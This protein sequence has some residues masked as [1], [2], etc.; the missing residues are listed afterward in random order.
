VAEKAPEALVAQARA[1]RVTAAAAKDYFFEPTPGRAEAVA[2]KRL[3]AR[4]RRTDADRA[5]EALRGRKSQWLVISAAAAELSDEAAWAVEENERFGASLGKAGRDLAG[6]LERAAERLC[7]AL[8]RLDEA[9]D[10]LAEAK[11]EALKIED[12]R[13][14]ARKAALDRPQ[15]AAEL[16]ARA[17]LDRFS[18]AAEAVHRAAD[19]A[20][21]RLA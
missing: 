8:E 16:S 11:N 19:A 9:Q 14:K 18:R 13:R 6:G 20:A 4:L 12:I 21:E 1:A 7:A 17:V 15:L 5:I 3:Q 10:P 2:E